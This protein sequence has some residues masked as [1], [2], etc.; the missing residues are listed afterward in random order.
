MD[1]DLGLMHSC[2]FYSTVPLRN[3]ECRYYSA[4]RLEDEAVSKMTQYLTQSHFPDFELASPC[5]I[6]LMPSAKLGHEKYKFN[7]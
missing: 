6:L 1:T 2:R 3:H 7:E 4:P 5:P